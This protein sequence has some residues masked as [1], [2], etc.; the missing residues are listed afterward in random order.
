MRMKFLRIFPEIWAST[1]WP[2]GR[3]TRN[4]V[5]GSTC[6]TVPVNSIGSSVA[7]PTYPDLDTLRSTHLGQDASLLTTAAATWALREPHL[8]GCGVQNQGT[9]A[10]KTYWT[11][12]TESLQCPALI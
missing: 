9:S 12:G 3:A 6:V 11:T 5:P 2:F 8:A 1:S 4:I 10:A 7:T